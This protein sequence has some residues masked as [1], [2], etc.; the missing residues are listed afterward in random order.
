MR[1]FSRL[2]GWL[3]SSPVWHSVLHCGCEVYRKQVLPTLSPSCHH[4][5]N[6]ADQKKNVETGFSIHVLIVLWPSASMESWV[7][8]TLFT[9][10][11]FAFNLY[12][13]CTL[14]TP[15][16]NVW[17]Q[18]W[19]YMN[20]VAFSRTYLHMHCGFSINIWRFFHPNDKHRSDVESLK[21][22]Y[23]VLMFLRCSVEKKCEIFACE[24]PKTIFEG[25]RGRMVIR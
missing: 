23:W 20:F 25:S 3:A 1:R 11:G 7:N 24:P 5:T 9:S 17:S 16:K 22:V 2:A 4:R 19:R 8:L 13:A 12:Q 21:H 10:V 6:S 14:G 18:C 15:G